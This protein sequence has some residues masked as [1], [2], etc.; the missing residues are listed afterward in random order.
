MNQQKQK[1]ASLRVHLTPKA[2]PVNFEKLPR[3]FFPQSL[4]HISKQKT[5]EESRI[6]HEKVASPNK[7]E[8]TQMH[9]RHS[10]KHAWITSKI[11]Q[12]QQ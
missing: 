2:F 3:R 7:K 1:V 10:K 6:F 5:L 8:E 11:F 9:C 12:Q 4:V